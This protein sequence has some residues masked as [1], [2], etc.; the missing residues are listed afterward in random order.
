M[1]KTS[2]LPARLTEKWD[3]YYES[4]SSP[5]LLDFPQVVKEPVILD[6]GLILPRFLSAYVGWPS[7]GGTTNRG[8]CSSAFMNAETEALTNGCVGVVKRV[9]PP[10]ER[11]TGLPAVWAGRKGFYLKTEWSWKSYKTVQ[12]HPPQN[13]HKPQAKCYSFGQTDSQ[14]DA[15]RLAFH[16]A[17]HLFRLASTLVELKFAH[18]SRGKFFTIWPP[19]ASRHKLIASQLYIREIYV[20]LRLA[21]TCEPTGESVW[22]PIASPYASSQGFAN[23]RRRLASTCESVWPK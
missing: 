10:V 12:F 6:N 13:G 1:Y 5:H 16:L 21:W 7:T 9:Q 19:N 18:A 15:F 23:L 2:G 11:A 22:P 17:T 20:F 3:K 14:V 8:N 4:K